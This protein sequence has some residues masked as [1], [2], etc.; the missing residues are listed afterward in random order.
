GPIAGGLYRLALHMHAQL[1]HDP[2]GSGVADLSDTDDALKPAVH[3]TEAECRA[4]GL[5]CDSA[6]P[7]GP[8]Q[9]PADRNGG[10]TL[11]QELRPR[12]SGEPRKLAGGSY[13]DREQPEA[14]LV[15]LPLGRV[16]RGTGLVLVAD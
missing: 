6:A 7:E 9:P 16:D 3:K 13:L 15:P 12:Q 1:R 4:S 11:A 2:F 8:S 10:H 14:V 5:G